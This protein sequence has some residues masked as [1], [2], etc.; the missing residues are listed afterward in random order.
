MRKN[1]LIEFAKQNKI[2]I[3][4]K[5]TKPKIVET[6]L[7]NIKK[8]KTK[9]TPPKIKKTVTTKKDN[10]EQ[11]KI[12]NDRFTEL[13]PPNDTNLIEEVF[14]EEPM[15]YP[16]KNSKNYIVL[17]V[18]NPYWCFTYWNIN[19]EKTGEA[20]EFFGRFFKEAKKALRVLNISKSES[21]GKDI[22]FDIP[23]DEYAQSWYINIPSSNNRYKVL[24]GLKYKHKFFILAESNTVFVPGSTVS[25]EVISYDKKAVEEYIHIKQHKE[26]SKEQV[27]KKDAISKQEDN[28]FIKTVSSVNMVNIVSS[29]SLLNNTVNQTVNQN[30]NNNFFYN[31]NANITLYG[32][33]KPGTT[34]IIN[35][36]QKIKVN[37]EGKFSLTFPLSDGM[38]EI[39]TE[40]ISS[41]N[42]HSIV[43]RPIISK[44]TDY[45]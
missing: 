22:F 28:V 1:D 35:E 40:A 34:I 38:L 11:S 13:T 27:L 24:L 9:T 41:D 33:T 37:N 26:S 42:K 36:K 30:E 17:M 29:H 12:K 3:E 44:K 14:E 10:K 23:I 45:A 4:E 21:K 19:D 2:K 8:R 6:I 32:Q 43:I 16:Y 7:N 18:Q 5:L 15:L 39:K 20:K 31:L 25:E